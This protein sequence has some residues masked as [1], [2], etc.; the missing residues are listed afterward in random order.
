MR[1]INVAH[2]I[3]IG[4]AGQVNISTLKMCCVMLMLIT[5]FFI[6][7]DLSPYEK[8]QNFVL[9]RQLIRDLQTNGFNATSF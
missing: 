2:R 7:H 1:F 3:I 6:L 5:V 4:I 9:I 8:C